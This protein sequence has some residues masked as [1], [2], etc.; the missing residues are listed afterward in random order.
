MAEKCPGMGGGKRRQ[1]GSAD[2]PHGRGSPAKISPKGDKAR[3]WNKKA[4]AGFRGTET[5]PRR[6][7]ASTHGGHALVKSKARAKGMKTARTHCGAREGGDVDKDGL[8]RRIG[9]GELGGGAM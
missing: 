1:R 5:A 7:M 3:T 6:L 2:G 4:G 9:G 8:E